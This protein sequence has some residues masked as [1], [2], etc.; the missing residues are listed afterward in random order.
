MT[1]DTSNIKQ[2][3]PAIKK[4]NSLLE[5]I[6]T[7][8]TYYDY[9]KSVY[10]GIDNLITIICPIHGEFKQTPYAHF[11][12][13][14]GCNK[15]AVEARADS[16]RKSKED[17]INKANKVHNSKYDYSKVNYK[18]TNTKVTIICPEHVDFEQQPADHLRG[19]ACSKCSSKDI[20]VLTKEEFVIRANKVHK[21]K[22]DYTKSIYVRNKYKLIIT[23]QYHGDFTQTASD[24][25]N[26]N[27]CQVCG[28]NRKR[29]KYFSEPTILYYL[30]FP[31]FNAYKIGITLKSRGIKKRFNTEKNLEYRV[32]KETLYSIGKEAYLEEQRILKENAHH[33]YKGPKFFSKGGE[34]ECFNIDILGLNKVEDI[35]WSMT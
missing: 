31:A 16:K 28:E 20:N 35:V 6:A 13:N 26:G 34:S 7:T 19:H 14:R 3:E 8:H 24:H 27:G 21:S 4:F 33:L 10:T 2:K 29:A 18:N 17:F 23:C 32:L 1:L 9:S 12:L 5:Q 15:C 22:Y 25:L 11:N 30:Y